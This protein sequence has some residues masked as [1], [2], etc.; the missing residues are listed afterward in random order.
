MLSMLLKLITFA[1]HP[2]EIEIHHNDTLKRI[3][4]LVYDESGIP[5][6]HQRMV[7]R[8][9]I[10]YNT[11]MTAEDYGMV[12]GSEVRLIMWNTPY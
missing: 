1:E 11:R 9:R 4:R 2:I 12:S 7:W 5:P 3:K 6:K 8:G 10:M